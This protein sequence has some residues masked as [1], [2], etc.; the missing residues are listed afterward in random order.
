MAGCRSV[1]WLTR[2]V[3]SSEESSSFWQRSDYKS[4]SPGVDW[5]SVD[6]DS[7]PA[8]QAMPVTSAICEPARG[9]AVEAGD[10]V[11]VRGYAWSG[12]GNGVI[13]VDV[14]A[15]GGASWQVAALRR[16]A[17]QGA[18]RGWAW[19]L[20]EAEVAVPKGHVGPLTLVAK[21]TDESYNTQPERPEAVWNLRGV[22]CNSWPTVTVEV[23]A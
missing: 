22:A 2:I 21:A 20:W 9:A 18:G 1:K 12:G 11:T 10:D 8:I 3:A 6:W 5:D 13:R 16:V 14:S 19:V 23:Q 17:G 15:D 7:A 4:F